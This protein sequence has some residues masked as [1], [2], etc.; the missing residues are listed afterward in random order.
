MVASPTP[1]DHRVS[2]P[3]MWSVW[4]NLFL[5]MDRHQPALPPPTITVST[6][7]SLLSCHKLFIPCNTGWV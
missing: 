2:Y 7:L 5:N 6:K 3:K 1:R 4:D